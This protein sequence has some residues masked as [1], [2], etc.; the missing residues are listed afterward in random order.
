MPNDFGERPCVH[1]ADGSAYA[2]A[3][4]GP[5]R[6]L[7]VTCLVGEDGAGVARVRIRGVPL[8]L[9][10]WRGDHGACAEWVYGETPETWHAVAIRVG[11]S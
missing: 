10:V 7:E 5:G 1:Y 2:R 3:T 4:S 6:T 8:A 9:F 11:T